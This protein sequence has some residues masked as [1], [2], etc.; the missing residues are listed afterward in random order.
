MT[1]FVGNCLINKYDSRKQH[2]VIIESRLKDMWI[3]NNRIPYNKLNIISVLYWRALAEFVKPTDEFNDK[4]EK[5][6][7]LVLPDLTP[8]CQYIRE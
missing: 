3:T 2:D 4:N 8:F 7:Q 5:I 1:L 6:F